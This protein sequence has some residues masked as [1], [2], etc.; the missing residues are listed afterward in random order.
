MTGLTRITRK[1]LKT[2][3]AAKRSLILIGDSPEFIC[4]H[5]PTHQRASTHGTRRIC[6]VAQLPTL[7]HI[8]LLPFSRCRGSILC[9]LDK[10]KW[11]PLAELISMQQPHPPGKKTKADSIS[12]SPSSSKRCMNYGLMD[13]NNTVPSDFV[14][15]GIWWQWMQHFRWDVYQNQKS[16]VDSNQNQNQSFSYS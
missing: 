14:R 4:N 11:F 7:T 2:C 13:R 9:T 1:R 12:V 3:D 10:P 8:L 6:P 15:Y 16:W 5:T